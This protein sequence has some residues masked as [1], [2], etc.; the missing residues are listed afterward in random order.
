VDG[1]FEAGLIG[2]SE[3]VGHP[4]SVI[5]GEVIQLLTDLSEASSGYLIAARTVWPREGSRQSSR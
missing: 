1:N 4:K 2:F 3:A 5:L